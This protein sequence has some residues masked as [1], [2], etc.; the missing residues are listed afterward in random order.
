[1]VALESALHLREL[2]AAGRAAVRSLVPV[3]IRPL[4]DDARTDAESGLETIARLLFRGR[5]IPCRTQVRFRGVGRVDLLV[6]DRLVIE[7]DGEEFHTGLQFD[8][9]RRRDLELTLRGYLVIRLSW[10]MV[11]QE[12]DAVERGL[13]ELVA[14]GA[15]R[16]GSARPREYPPFT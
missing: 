8:E 10:R 15:H 3:R 13:L 2:D 11:V 9:D 1:M 7:L 12:W 5:R 14:R 16:W 6:G 4:V